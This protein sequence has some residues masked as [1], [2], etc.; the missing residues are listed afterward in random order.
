MNINK[1]WMTLIELI[2]TITIFAITVTIIYIT[3]TKNHSKYFLSSLTS[4]SKTSIMKKIELWEGCYKFL[5]KPS[6][7][8]WYPIYPNLYSIKS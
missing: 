6:N 3:Y 4:I 2:I 1:K 7:T 5:Q 8:P